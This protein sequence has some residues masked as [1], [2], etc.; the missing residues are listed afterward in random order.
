V[1]GGVDSLRRIGSQAVA[2]R[3]VPKGRPKNNF[4]FDSFDF[5]EPRASAR[6]VNQSWR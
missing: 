5:G 4:L 1:P 3:R 2:R 6:G